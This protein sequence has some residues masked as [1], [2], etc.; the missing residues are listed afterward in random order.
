MDTRSRQSAVGSQQS[1]HLLSTQHSALSAPYD[2]LIDVGAYVGPVEH[3]ACGLVAMVERHGHAT[4]ENVTRVLHALA[5][6]HHRSGEI[7]G[8]GDGCGI[9]TDIPRTLWARDLAALGYDPSLA[10]DARFAVGHFF[11]PPADREHAGDIMALVDAVIREAGCDLCISRPMAVVSDALGRLGRREEP[12]TWQIAFRTPSLGTAARDRLLF[13][14]QLAIEARTAALTVSLSADSVVYK[15]RG[16]AQALA[17]YYPDLRDPTF[18]SAISIGHNRYSTN[19]TT[20]FERVQPFSLLGHNG[21][22]NTIAKFRTESQMLHIPLVPG[23]SDS[24]DVNRTLEGMIHRYNLSVREALELIFPPIVNEIKRV[25]DEM[26][27]VL[28]YFRQAWGPFAQGPAA[29]AIRA[30]DEL[31][32]TVDALGLRPLW[33]CIAKDRIVFSSEKGVVP[34]AEMDDDPKPLAPGEKMAIILTRGVGTQVETY[35]GIL[36]DVLNRAQARGISATDYRRFLVCQSPKVEES[37]VGSRQSAKSG[38]TQSSVLNPQSS[39]LIAAWA[40]DGE[41]LKLT[42]AMAESG[43]ERVG[44]LGYDGPLAALSRERQNLADYFKE[45]VAV[46][47]NP[48]ID[49]EREI[50]QFSTRVVLGPRPPIGVADHDRKLPCT[51]L[52]TP[53]F[54]GGLRPGGG[55]EDARLHRHRAVAHQMGTWT[56]E[57]FM[58]FEGDTRPT[59][60][61]MAQWPGEPLRVALHR[62]GEE[63]V[64]AAHSGTPLIVLDDEGT[65]TH[66]NRPIDPLL[67]ISAVDT[68]LRRASGGPDGYALRRGVGLIMRSAGIRTLHDIMLAIGMGADA[69]CPY[70]QWEIA[71]AVSPDGLANLIAALTKGIEKVISTIGIH[72][73][74]GYSRLFASIGLH[75]EVARMFGAENYGGSATGGLSWEQLEAVAEERVRI[76]A[77]DVKA[78]PTRVA[79]FYPKVWKSVRNVAA[80]VEPYRD[81]S[82]KVTAL[83]AENPVSLRHLLD[84]RFPSVGAVREPPSPDHPHLPHNTQPSQDGRFT[85]RPYADATGIDPASVDAGIGGH[86]YPIAISSMSFGSQGETAFRAYPEAAMRLNIVSLNGEG[87]EIKDMIGRYPQWRGQQIASGRFGVNAELANSS[88]L[89]EI[90]IGQ[91]AKPGEGGHLP[92]SKVSEKVA[93]ARNA[94]PGVDLISPSNNHDIYSIEDLAQLVDELK[95]A[96]PNV[97]VSVKVPVVPGIGTIA[98]GIAKSGADIITL[99]GYDGGTG[100]ARTHALK[101]VGLP[102]DIGVV[103]AHRALVAAGLREQVELWADG[104]MRTGAD[105]V[106]MLLLG[107]NRIGFGT[108]PMVAIGCTICRGCQLDTCHVGIATQMET[109]EEARAKGVTHFVPRVYEEAVQQLVRFLG[110]IGEEIKELTAALGFTRTQDLV[111]RADLLVQT[112]MR[113]R[114]DLTRM[115]APAEQAAWLREIGA[116]RTLRVLRIDRSQHVAAT[117]ASHVARGNQ[118]VALSEPSVFPDHRVVG[119]VLAGEMTRA[120]LY[121]PNTLPTTATLAFDDGSVVGNGFACFNVDGVDLTVEGGAQDGVGKGALGGTIVILKGTNGNGARVDGSVGKSFAYGAQGGTFFVQGNADSRAGIRLSGADV[122]IGGEITAPIDDRRCGIATRA[123]IKGFAFE[124]MTNGRAVVLGDPGPWLC[125]G[126]TGGVVY[127]HLVPA[128]GLDRAAIGRRMAKGAKI[129]MADLNDADADA[130]TVLVTGYAERLTASGQHI[131]AERVRAMIANPKESFVKVVPEGQQVDPSISTE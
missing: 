96:N 24:Q 6:M 9:L 94:T 44:S 64:E 86:D 25:P 56:L 83:E 42:E 47:T 88:N 62:L 49:R 90:K 63:A 4:R 107:A 52:I 70:L 27:D 97:R 110:A 69:V 59:V 92:G 101:H 78:K 60:I 35:D 17:A 20:A 120:Q 51:E 3:D 131:A 33:L 40:F 22:I 21:E 23:A 18:V 130:V 16:T 19:T 84:F 95:T 66:G 102:S 117:V 36:R 26:A 13:D 109:D 121:E 48:A 61:A 73:V 5:T 74:R 2:P 14:L 127:Q 93:K 46:V 41:E 118:A 30:G 113:D 15:V 124:Y 91:G 89:L 11:V 108:L 85:N 10:G 54:T 103:E 79:H 116:D 39:R 71:E 50:E 57:D 105:V 106:R 43:N 34:I 80:G 77:G 45:S 38:D 67:A 58:T 114:V 53:L 112:R 119:T 76:A 65:L 12:T 32:G 128:M 104:G 126:M 28:M 29:M 122:V 100:A 98:V 72:E 99:S 75:V 81:Y 111:G 8:E 82:A 125:A 115:L 7:D 68:A 123:N 55:D 31:V 129:T 87:G 37:A 1:M